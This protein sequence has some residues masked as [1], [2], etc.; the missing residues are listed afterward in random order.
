MN[1]NKTDGRFNAKMASFYLS[2]GGNGLPHYRTM[3][4]S[5]MK[6]IFNKIIPNIQPKHP[7]LASKVERAIEQITQN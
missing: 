3:E 6:L 1:L 4:P 5:Q 7:E 2:K